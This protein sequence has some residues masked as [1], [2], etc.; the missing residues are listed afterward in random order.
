M[1]ILEDYRHFDG[2]HWETG[3]V[4][5]FMAYCGYTLPHND[6]PPS[7]ALLMGVSGGAVMGYFTF[8]YQGYDPQVNILTRN[9]FDPLETM[10]S[11]LGVEQAVKNTASADKGRR[12][13]V[14]VLEEGSPA[15]VWADPYSLPYNNLPPDDG[16]WGMMPIVVF[17]HSEEQDLVCIADR[18]RVPLQTTPQALQEA[19]SRIKKTKHRLLTLGPPNAGKLATA[20]REGIQDCLRLYLE[21][22]P[23]GAAHNF[24]F[25]AYRRWA[26]VL[27]QPQVRGSW[28][29]EFLAGSKMYAGLTSAFFF[30]NIFGKEDP[31]ERNVYADFLEE[32]AVILNIPA[33]R[34]VAEQ[35]RQS[36]QVWE[37]LSQALLPDE[38]PLLGETRGL[39]LRR[40]DLF[41]NQG[42][43]AL[44]EI[45][46]IDRRLHEL[47]QTA[48]DAFPLN[49]EQVVALRREIAGN[50]MRIHDAEHE[51]VM[52]LREAMSNA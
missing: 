48:G 38:L 9:T 45:K 14:D 15:I 11:R 52:A 36:A 51:A 26:E 4:H 5:N 6:R 30:I 13:L 25:A 17:G 50:V 32:A 2:R 24:G 47:R 39:M 28:E 37:A 7:E 20:V 12:N 8:A 27:T 33:L 21:K 46:E 1:P 49:Q 43:D 42:H 34:D 3:S 40:R 31:A 10:L 44:H 23:K 41:L 35:F 19:R 22:P 16:M 29:K 18:A